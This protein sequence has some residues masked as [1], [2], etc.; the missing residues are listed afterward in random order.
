M[1]LAAELH[2][3]PI[4]MLAERLRQGAVSAVDVTRHMLDRIDRVDAKLHSYVL[5]M[6][7]AAL[8]QA[9]KADAELAR[10]FDRGLL[11]GVPLAIKDIFFTANAPTTAGSTFLGECNPRWDATAVTRLND[12]GAVL[13]GKLAMTEGAVSEH[14]PT[15]PIPVNPWHDDYWTGIS[16]SGSGVAVAAGLCFGALGTDTGGSIRMPSGS[17]GLSGIKPTWGRVSLH[18]VFPLCTTRDHAGPMAR[19]ARDA[20]IML[21]AIAGDDPEDPMSLAD[22]VDDY[23]GQL[24]TGIAGLR[25]GVDRRT[26]TEGVDAELAEALDTALALM[27]SL[28]ARICDVTYPSPDDYLENY[29]AETA[30]EIAIAHEATFPA[31]ADEYGAVLRRSIEAA[32][33]VTGSD[34]VRVAHKRERFKGD[35]ARLFARVDVLFLPLFPIVTQTAARMTEL[36]SDPRTFMRLLGRYTIPFNASGSPALVLPCGFGGNGLPLPMQLVGRHCG[37]ATLFRIGAAYQSR[38]DWHSRHPGWG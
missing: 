23:V 20:A 28:G 19:N 25:I 36:S 15:R 3:W 6:G 5:V 2:Y 32:A 26:L 34:V 11:H 37:E 24:D 14:P 21:A 35:L 13:L 33:N 17:C 1:T 38:T 22:P 10:G 8:D 31:R 16:S 30:A 4:T 7:E 27:E 18:G 9:R 12:A 29:F